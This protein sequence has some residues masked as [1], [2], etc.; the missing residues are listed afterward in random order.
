MKKNT[1]KIIKF[2]GG[3]GNQMFQYAFGCALKEKFK[4]DVAFDFEFFEE[5]KKNDNVT[6]RVFEMGVFK[7]ECKEATEENLAKIKRPE[8]DSKFKNTLAKR[9]PEL[10]RIN[11]VR[12]KK[13]TVFDKNL[14]SKKY[15]YFEGYFQNEKYFKHIR[16]TLLKNF[17]L[18]VPLDNNNEQ[19][20]NKIKTTQAVSIHV[21]RGDYVNLDYVNKI[22]G[23]CSLDYYKK[24]IDYISK[25]VEAPYFFLFS[26]D[27][28]W[29]NQ[30]LKI[31]FPHEIVNINDGKGWFDMEL[32]KHCKHNIIA[33]SSFSWWAAWLNENPNKIIIAPKNWMAKKQKC[34]IVPKRWIK[35]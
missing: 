34:N 21:R 4:T 19:V 15:D 10:F 25:H 14:L 18:K 20:L 16:E 27:V 3:L 29:V 24:A 17:S 28:E 11:Y 2:N 31:D 35:L 23:A 7:V 1:Q 6:S 32:M 13:N 12:E 33:N 8:F 30:N 9:F 26:D 5:V 22:H